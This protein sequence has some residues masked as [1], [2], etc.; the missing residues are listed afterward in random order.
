MTQISINKKYNI[1][2]QEIS[3]YINNK[4]L[5]TTI[6]TFEIIN[7]KLL[8]KITKEFNKKT[9]VMEWVGHNTYYVD[10]NS[11]YKL[12]SN[13]LDELFEMFKAKKLGLEVPERK[14]KLVMNYDKN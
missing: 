10:N 9:K 12:K 6:K 4:I 13:S 1:S 14:C 7:E 2:T 3:Y 11:A 8:D 5:Y